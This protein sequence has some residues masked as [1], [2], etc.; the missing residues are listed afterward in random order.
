MCVEVMGGPRCQGGRAVEAGLGGEGRNDL[1][2]CGTWATPDGN[3]DLTF[4]WSAPNTLR[5]GKM[6][7]LIV[8]AVSPR[9]LT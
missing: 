6:I 4:F 8:T 3:P 9:G 1:R 5:Q 7:P 2:T